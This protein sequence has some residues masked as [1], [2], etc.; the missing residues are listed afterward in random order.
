MLI[1]ALIAPP[2]CVQTITFFF[3]LFLFPFL[4][5]LFL[6]YLRTRT[7]ITHDG[8]TSQ[9]W[10]VAHVVVFFLC[11]FFYKREEERN[12]RIHPTTTAIFLTFSLQ[13]QSINFISHHV[14]DYHHRCSCCLRCRIRPCFQV[15]LITSSTIT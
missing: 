9:T 3:F 13:Q 14:Q 4:S 5:F 6:S 12:Q 8:Y 15:S 2:S 11:V 10:Q 7:Y 1:V